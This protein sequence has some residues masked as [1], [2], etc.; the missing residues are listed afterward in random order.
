[1]NPLLLRNLQRLYLVRARVFNRQ[2]LQEQNINEVFEPLNNF[3]DGRGVGVL[4]KFDEL[5]NFNLHKSFPEKHYE[6]LNTSYTD[7]VYITAVEETRNLQSEIRE[8]VK[9]FETLE[10]SVAD[11]SLKVARSNGPWI[12][13]KVKSM[14]SN[15]RSYL[16]PFLEYLENDVNKLQQIP[17]GSKLDTKNENVKNLLNQ[18]EE[19]KLLQELNKEFNSNFTSAEDR[20][21][22]LS[23]LSPIVE[24][25]GTLN[26]LATVSMK[27]AN[28]LRFLSSGPRS[29]YGE[30]AIPENEPGSSIMPGKVN[31]TQCESLTMV[32]SQVLGN[33]VAVS[34]GNASALFESNNFKP[35][36]ANNTLR[37][38]RLLTDGLRSFRTNCAVGIQLIEPKI[39]ENL[40]LL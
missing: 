11:G 36:I 34:I 13:M 16:T 21:V 39:N 40:S 8:L 24:L 2:N 5:F 32:A 22:S 35:L 9:T 17:L 31:P 29:G 19:S 20:L 1:V 27:M 38:L 37:S 7:A 10:N 30:L 25:S 23:Q 15:W 3:S 26:N 14:F 4:K 33:H 6:L 18:S 12:D 28:D